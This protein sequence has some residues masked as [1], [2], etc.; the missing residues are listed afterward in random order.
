MEEIALGLENAGQPFIWVVRSRTWIP[1]VGWEER[2]KDRG[3]DQQ[4]GLSMGVPL[5]G[6]PMGTEQGLNAR[7]VAM[8]LKAGLM[9]L[10]EQD[11]FDAKDDPMAVQHNV[12]CDVVKELMQGDQGRKARERAQEFGIKARQAVEKGGSSDKK[13]DELIESLTPRQNNS[14]TI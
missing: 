8:G 2:V 4:L 1:P 13:L 10:Q 14:R 3:L 11:K 6:W 5:L 7:Y 9:V 12:I